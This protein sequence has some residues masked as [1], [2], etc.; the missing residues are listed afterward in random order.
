[1]QVILLTE[2]EEHMQTDSCSSVLQRLQDGLQQ[3]GAEALDDPL[4]QPGHS[5]Q[6]LLMQEVCLVAT[7]GTFLT[8]KGRSRH[9]SWHILSVICSTTAHPQLNRLAQQASSTG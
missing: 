6:R 8:L 5:D 7:Q 1:M 4:Q 2:C 3:F 9:V